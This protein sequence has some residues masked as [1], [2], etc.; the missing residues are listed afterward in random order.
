MHCNYSEA[1]FSN[2]ILLT[3]SPSTALI[4]EKHGRDEVKTRNKDNKEGK[5]LVQNLKLRLRCSFIDAPWEK[6]TSITAV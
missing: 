4:Q 6:F 5:N 1:V 2:D 3:Q